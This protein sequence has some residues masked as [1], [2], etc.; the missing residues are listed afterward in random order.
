M[1][2]FIVKVEYFLGEELRKE[3]EPHLESRILEKINS[4]FRKKCVVKSNIKQYI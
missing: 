3:I 4:L 1:I 2:R